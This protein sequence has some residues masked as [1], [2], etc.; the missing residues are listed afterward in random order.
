MS[1]WN[2]PA[3]VPVQKVLHT[4]NLNDEWGYLTSNP[5]SGCTMSSNGSYV[6]IYGASNGT[7]QIEWSNELHVSIKYWWWS[8]GYDPWVES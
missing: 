6:E 8:Y 7:V 1:A 3:I 5:P 4:I 2:I